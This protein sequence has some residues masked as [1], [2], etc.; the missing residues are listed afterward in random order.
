MGQVLSC[1]EDVATYKIKKS[2][3]QNVSIQKPIFSFGAYEHTLIT[4]KL[5][6]R[7]DALLSRMEC[8]RQLVVAGIQ[9][10]WVNDKL[11]LSM[12]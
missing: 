9:S 3:K 4:K 7:N 5:Q 1:S 10:Y 6:V 8:S 11:F 2:T 12:L